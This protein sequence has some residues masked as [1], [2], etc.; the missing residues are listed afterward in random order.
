MCFET[1]I[2]MNECTIPYHNI[3]IQQKQERI[4]CTE[5]K[6]RNTAKM[7]LKKT[8]KKHNRN[9]HDTDDGGQAMGEELIHVQM[10]R[11]EASAQVKEASSNTVYEAESNAF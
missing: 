4:T 3:K 7:K 5:K 2:R 9:Q 11:R 10:S 8:T 6:N 1:N